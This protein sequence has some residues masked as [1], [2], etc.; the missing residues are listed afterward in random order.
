MKIE[1]LSIDGFGQFF[2]R[3]FGPFDTPL[4]V[5]AG[6]N[7]AGKSTLVAFII[8]VLFGF[9][10]KDDVLH[11]PALAGGKHGGRLSIIDDA[12]NRYMIQRHAGPGR[13]QG[14]VVVTR[15]EGS[16]AEDGVLTRLLSAATPDLFRS[17]FAFDLEQLQ[18][19]RAAD[20]TDISAAIYGAGLGVKNLSQ[21]IAKFD[22]CMGTIF[23]PRG[24]TQPI[25][26][27]RR[28]LEDTDQRLLD[29]R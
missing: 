24:S 11:I 9:Q 7:E 12:G 8:T 27:I 10:Q 23:K 6:P 4:T 2:N 5:I 21:T 3:E 28:K 18:S 17:A 22:D 16:P 19:L 29:I 13:S 26:E 15:E 14:Q 1:H 20:N 25:E